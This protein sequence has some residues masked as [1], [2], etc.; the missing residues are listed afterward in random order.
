MSR[1]TLPPRASSEVTSH[2]S[3]VIG[4]NADREYFSTPDTIG[5]YITEQTCEHCNTYN[6]LRLTEHLFAWSPDGAWFDYYERAH[7]NHVMAA[8]NPH[9]GGFT[10][11]TPLM[12]G[13]AREYSDPADDPFWC[14]VGTGMESHAKHGAAI[15]WEGEGTLLVNLYI[16]ATAHW[17]A[18]GADLRLETRYPFESS[19]RLTCGKARPTR[20]HSHCA[21]GSG[22]GPTGCRQPERQRCA[23]R[24]VKYKG[25]ALLE[26]RWKGDVVAITSAAGASH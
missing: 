12:A 3:Y 24:I 11:M 4:G 19:A 7:L 25:Y 16:P 26:R 1:R 21:A 5:T 2:H 6:M 18:R 22:W 8:H 9:S 14:C 23:C 15:F 13:A 17:Q 20:A 10:Y